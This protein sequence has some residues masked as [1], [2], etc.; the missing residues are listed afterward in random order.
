MGLGIKGLEFR[1]WGL[2]FKGLEFRVWGL[3][4]RV[5][6]WGLRF[7]VLHVGVDGSQGFILK[8][9]VYNGALMGSAARGFVGFAG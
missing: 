7:R 4:F 1:V 2:E 9:R 6:V 3:G 8:T 5:W